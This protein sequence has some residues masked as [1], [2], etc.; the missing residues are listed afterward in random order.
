MLEQDDFEAVSIASPDHWHTSMAIMGLQAGK[1]VYVEKPCCFNPNEGELLVKAVKK[2]NN[3]MVQMG[4]QQRSAKLSIKAINEIKDG[5][6]GDAY[7]AKAWYANN[8]KSI[9]NGKIVEVPDWLDW[10]LF[11]GPA[12]RKKYQDNVVHY[13]WHWFRH[14]GSG[15]INNNALHELDVCRWGLGVDYPVKVTS[16]GG[17]FHY[18]DDWE[19]FDTQTAN[20]EFSDGKMIT[21]EGKSCN[22][23]QIHGRGR[24]AA[25]HGT[26]GTALLDRNSYEVYDMDNNLVKEEKSESKTETL[27]TAGGG[28]LDLYHYENFLNAIREGEE[29]HSPIPDAVISNNYCHYG[30]I[31][32]DVGRTLYLDQNT[33]RILNDAQ[34][35]QMCYR[36]YE[37]GWEIKV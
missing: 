29:L 16:S 26:K 11:Q 24:G 3:L 5:I 37:P 36:E 2:Y 23:F 17:R 27:G 4:N 30:N 13:N 6:I 22:P 21:W 9:G 14:W 12:P 18:D 7:Y 34:A 25:F 28:P 1:H 32:Q 15:E 8:R 33:G 31:A 35:T 10:D 19:F 20:Y